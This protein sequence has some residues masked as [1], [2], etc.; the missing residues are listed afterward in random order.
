M[1]IRV[2][3]QTRIPASPR[4]TPGSR[5]TAPLLTMTT[6]IPVLVLL[7]LAACRG[8]ETPTPEIAA[9]VTEE[10]N[11]REIG[12]APRYFLASGWVGDTLWGLAGS[13]L[14]FVR[15]DAPEYRAG[16]RRYWD[17]SLS[18]R[19][20]LAGI[21]ERGVWVGERLLLDRAGSAEGDLSGPP[22]WSP[23]G[24]RLLVRRVREGPALH[25]AIDVES[26]AVTPLPLRADSLFLGE[27]FWTSEGQI[28]LTAHP[29]LDPE[30]GPVG[31]GD[32]YL[33]DPLR[34][35]ARAPEGVF[36]RPLSHWG[37]HAV[38]VGESESALTPATRFRVYDTRSW[39]ASAIELPA[40][41]RVLAADSTRAVLVLRQEGAHDPVHRL[42]LWRSGQGVQ[43][44][45]DVT[46]RDLRLAWSPDGRRLAVST[47][48][49]EIDQATG[50]VEAYYR[51]G[52]AEPR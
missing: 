1:R 6:R 25:L 32:L 13:T 8:E 50:S 38:L 52:I 35:I 3:A 4:R 12:H 39:T 45:R 42:S 46:G 47:A 14:A 24:A 33:L 5:V 7:L 15:T 2:L 18:A 30:R 48:G 26:G 49:E 28:I 29:S 43:P 51:T 37:D 9:A 19:G 21:D 17:V 11:F 31:R 23:D 34:R 27:P 16:R 40:A 36:L 22:L 20:A 44:L 10:W 41:D